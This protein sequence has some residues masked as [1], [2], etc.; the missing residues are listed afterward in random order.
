VFLQALIRRILSCL[1]RCAFCN[2]PDSDGRNGECYT[3]HGRL[4]GEKKPATMN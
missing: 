3:F 1:G 4:F 2:K